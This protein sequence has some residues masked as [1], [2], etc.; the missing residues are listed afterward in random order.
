[1][2]E[3][4][5][6]PMYQSQ[7]MKGLYLA[8]ETLATTFVRAPLWA[9]YA[10]PRTNRPRSSWPL[11]RVMIIKLIQHMIS[12]VG[13]TGQWWH[14]PDHLAVEQGPNVKGIWISPAPDLVV[15]EV[16]QWAADAD[17]EPIQIPGYW[18]EKQGIDLP[19]NSPPRPGEKVIYSLHGGGF[20]ACSAHPNDGTSNIPKGIL[21]HTSPHIVRAFTVEYRLLKHH[22]VKPY[23]PFPAALFDVIAGYNHLV[24]IVGFAPED[25]VV[26]GD[27]AGGNLGIALIRYLIENQD[28]P[29]TKIPRIPSALV[30]C[31][32]WVDLAPATQ[33]PLAAV[34]YNI[35]SDYI[36]IAANGINSMITDYC[37]PLGPSATL[38][39]RYISPATFFSST[40]VSF[41]GFPRTFI[42]SGGAEVML[43]SI[44]LLRQ[45]MTKDMGANL[46]TYIEE[47]LAVHDF[48][49]HTWHEPERTE[50]LRLVA[51]WIE[52]LGPSTSE[53]HAHS[54]GYKLKS[55]L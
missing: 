5:M 4:Q 13:K 48:L 50:C 52:E 47:S 34:Q 26:E 25:I 18:L 7:P 29:I 32:P 39:N 45:R 37:G 22:S 38:T 49:I 21:K 42:L 14:D 55:K 20:A 44:R 36:C 15:G 12:V 53:S 35:P 23:N 24:N 43:D 54:Q 40:N 17:L 10:L 30:L 31:S 1:M 41:K 19:A 3:K 2:S 6:G 9:L 46:V 16:K 27:S 8:K 51:Q 33:D 28:H 11:R